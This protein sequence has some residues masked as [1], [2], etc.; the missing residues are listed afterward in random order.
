MFLCIHRKCLLLTTLLVYE[1]G[2]FS[3][4]SPLFNVGLLLNQ[5]WICFKSSFLFSSVKT[6]TFSPKCFPSFADW[7]KLSW[8]TP[9]WLVIVWTEHC[10]LNNDEV[11][12]L[13]HLFDTCIIVVFS[14]VLFLLNFVFLYINGYFEEKYLL[15]CC[16]VPLWRWKRC[17]AVNYSRLLE[18]LDCKIQT[19]RRILIGRGKWMWCV[20]YWYLF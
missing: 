13:F 2:K 11:M 5:L 1:K 6:Y 9:I 3:V 12:A 14:K 10:V 4:F 18:I 7:C 20:G 16:F 15:V 17:T 8:H 19:S